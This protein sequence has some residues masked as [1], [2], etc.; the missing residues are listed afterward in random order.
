MRYSA[1]LFYNA[2]HAAADK[3]G[4]H[5][6]KLLQRQ[7]FTV[8]HP[9]AVQYGRDASEIGENQTFLL[10]V[11][12]ED[13]LVDF[14][15]ML[16]DKLVYPVAYMAVAPVAHKGLVK[17]GGFGHALKIIADDFSYILHAAV[18]DSLFCIASYNL[19][20]QFLQEL[21]DAFVVQIES[22]AVYLGPGSQLLYG[23]L[24]IVHLAYHVG[25]GFSYSLMSFYDPEVLF[26]FHIPSL[27]HT[28]TLNVVYALNKFLQTIVHCLGIRY[29]V[30]HKI[31]T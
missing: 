11:K 20:L 25:K 24:A 3:L 6:N 21:I 15:A 4:C 19:I 28:L 12:A 9:L 23:D 30:L 14:F 8:G 1:L 31:A 16:H 7:L 18:G 17:F 2:F 10:P 29:T 22:L 5:C 13:P 26:S 27:C